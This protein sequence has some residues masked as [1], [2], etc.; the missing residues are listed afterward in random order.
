MNK[1]KFNDNKM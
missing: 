1:Q